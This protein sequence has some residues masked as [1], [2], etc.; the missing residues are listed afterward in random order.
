MFKFAFMTNNCKNSRKVQHE[1]DKTKSIFYEKFILKN[2][3]TLDKNTIITFTYTI[4][5]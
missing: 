3:R 2:I 4:D 5:A 1:R